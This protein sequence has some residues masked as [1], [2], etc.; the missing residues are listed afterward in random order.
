MYVGLIS[1]REL[2][3]HPFNYVDRTNASSIALIEQT[4]LRKMGKIQR[5]NENKQR[6]TNFFASTKT[7]SVNATKGS[8]PLEVVRP[9]EKVARSKENG[10]FPEENVV[11]LEV[12]VAAPEEKVTF[13]KEKVSPPKEKVSPPKEKVSTPKEKVSTPK[14]KVSTP[15]EKVVFLEEKV[16][17][18]KEKVVVLEEKVAPVSPPKRHNLEHKLKHKKG[19]LEQ[20]RITS[21]ATLMKFASKKNEGS[22]TKTKASFSYSKFQRAP[23]SKKKDNVI[24]TIS[25]RV[26]SRKQNKSDLAQRRKALRE[27]VRAKDQRT[28]EETL[29]GS[30]LSEK[31][32]RVMLSRLIDM[33]DSISFLYMT[34][35]KN[36]MYITDLA[37]KL[38]ESSNVPLS[39]G[40][41]IEHIELLS[42]IAP[43]WCKLS[44]SLERKKLVT[45][46]HSI[47]VNEV[48]KLIQG[49][50]DNILKQ[51]L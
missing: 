18:S 20:T 28:I 15:K 37:V 27:R 6:V 24:K 43:D 33:T 19:A 23:F 14:E 44:Y 8:K 25:T 40:E 29:Q 47:S 31:H 36:V 13:P 46:N 42:E 5:K 35:K 45:I 1:R 30:N 32:Q 48:L 34:S 2:N 12:K 3:Q 7:R 11:P 41:I 39:Q 16:T 38:K 50:M 4:S 17:A 51:T 22:N 21:F 9:K 10:T 26:P 49:R